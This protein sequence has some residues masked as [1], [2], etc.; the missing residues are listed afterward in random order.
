TTVAR[1]QCNG[2]ACASITWHSTFRRRSSEA[3]SRPVGPAP[4]TRTVVSANIL[5]LLDVNRELIREARYAKGEL[6][7]PCLCDAGLSLSGR[8]NVARAPSSGWPPPDAKHL[9]MF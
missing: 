7:G 8:G 5:N 4:T 2:V 9:K 6:P 3:S 1:S